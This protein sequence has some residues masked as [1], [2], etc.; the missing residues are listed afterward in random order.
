M[1][2]FTLPLDKGAD[3]HFFTRIQP[4]FRH[5]TPK[6]AELARELAETE[7]ATVIAGVGLPCVSREAR[8][9]RRYG[10]LWSPGKTAT[11]LQAIIAHLV[12][13]AAELSNNPVLCIQFGYCCK[14]YSDPYHCCISADVSGAKQ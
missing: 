4:D 12:E 11:Q 6:H 10:V 1:T 3:V 14:H 13:E 7:I 9:G 2:T 8:I 5:K